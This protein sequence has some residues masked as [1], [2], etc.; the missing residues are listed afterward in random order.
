M[1]RLANPQHK[2]NK[3]EIFHLDVIKT[4]RNTLITESPVYSSMG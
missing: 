4:S 3:S 2:H 1:K